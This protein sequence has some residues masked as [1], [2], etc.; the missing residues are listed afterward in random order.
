ML[1][2]QATADGVFCMTGSQSQPRSNQNPTKIADI[3]DG[4]SNTL[5]FGE[6]YHADG[7]WD[8][9]LN[10]PFIPSP[11]PPMISIETVGVWAT[12]YPFGMQDVLLCGSYSINYRQPSAYTPP[13]IQIPPIPP[14]PVPW[15]SFLPNYVARVSAYGSG[16]TGGAN[17][18]LADGSVHFI[19]QTISIQ[20]LQGL[21]TRAGAEQVSVE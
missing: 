5:L 3:L 11:S 4:L 16:H 19:A 6:R 20:V 1:Y 12:S 14:P 7:N 9:W 2:N 8:S 10:A 15:A 18:A 17:F 13:P 21:S